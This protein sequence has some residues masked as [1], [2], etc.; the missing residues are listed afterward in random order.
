[1]N[2]I[3]RTILIVFF[4]AN[5][6]ILLVEA[7]TQD[8]ECE[9]GQWCSDHS[10]GSKFCKNYATLGA[11]C[12]AFTLPED[13]NICD[14]Q[15][16]F[17]YNPNKCIWPDG[18]GTCQQKTF[19]LH[20]GDCCST[21]DECASNI[22][23]FTITNIGTKQQICQASPEEDNN[24]LSAPAP[25]A[26]PSSAP[27]FVPTSSPLSTPNTETSELSQSSLDE[28]QIEDENEDLDSE[29]HEIVDCNI[30]KNKMRGIT[31]IFGSGGHDRRRVRHLRHR[32]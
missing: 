25:S 5:G 9:D 21:D 30:F 13:M 32:R 27:S 11:P 23:Q 12:E 31:S 17:C 7:C 19:K 20:E 14:P 8:S 18:G 10:N 6:D 22:C 3:L 4:I 16:H 29:T 15:V 24:I 28:E 1:M 26:A 2:F